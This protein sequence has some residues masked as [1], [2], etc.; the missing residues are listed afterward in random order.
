MRRYSKNIPM[1]FGKRFSTSYM[2]PI[3]RAAV[4]EGR[5]RY[6]V[7]VLQEAQRLDTVAG[8][9]YNN[10]SDYWIIA[11]ASGIGF[12]LQVPPGTVLTVP[13]LE[14]IENLAG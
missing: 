8:K 7:I 1:D 13:Y 10:S 6:R 14:D 9:Y 3:I 12:S 5:I 4:K 11:A 2:I